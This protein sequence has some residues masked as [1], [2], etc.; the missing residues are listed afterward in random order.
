MADS[1]VETSHVVRGNLTESE[2][3]AM[4][5]VDTVTCHQLVSLFGLPYYVKIDIEDAELALH[6]LASFGNLADF[7]N[8]CQLLC[9]KI[10]K[11]TSS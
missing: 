7:I 5:Q 2:C 1:E 4:L 9:G 3:A 6:C 11:Q 8:T 10:E